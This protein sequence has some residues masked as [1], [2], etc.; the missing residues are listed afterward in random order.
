MTSVTP[1]VARP[2]RRSRTVERV[3]PW[4]PAVAVFAI[5]ISADTVKI[6][7]K[8]EWSAFRRLERLVLSRGE[9]HRERSWLVRSE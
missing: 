8:R 7:R 3:Y 5:G 9:F 1:E 2:P 6:I 4:L